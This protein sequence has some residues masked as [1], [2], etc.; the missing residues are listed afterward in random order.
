MIDELAAAAGR[1]PVAFRLALLE[2]SPRAAGVLKLAAEKA[3]WGRPLR[4]GVAQGI[5]VHESFGSFVAQVAEVSLR[6]GKVKVERVVC[7]VDCGVPVNPDVIRAQMEGCIGFALG[8]MY[9]GEIEIKDGRAAQRNFDTYRSLRIHE[10]PRVEVH[11][12]AS[13]EK[14]SGVG[15]PGVPPLAPAVANAVAKLGGPRVRRLPLTRAGMV[16]V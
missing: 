2:K 14:P 10:M 7:A 8:A 6:K 4:P 1:D 11:I 12:V 16:E 9:Y 15:E 3:G 13:N 5:A